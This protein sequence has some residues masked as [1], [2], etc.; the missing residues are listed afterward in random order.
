MNGGSQGLID[1]SCAVVD[2]L[3][4]N[5]ATVACGS[6]V[7]VAALGLGVVLVVLVVQL[8][9]VVWRGTPLHTGGTGH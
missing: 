9:C 3:A 4:R 6:A 2:G 1:W 8:G 5:C 7:V